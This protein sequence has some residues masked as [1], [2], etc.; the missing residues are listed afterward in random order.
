[1]RM[2]RKKSR[3]MPGKGKERMALETL[4]DTLR[5]SKDRLQ[6]SLRGTIHNPLSRWSTRLPKRQAEKFSDLRELLD[7]SADRYGDSVLYKWFAKDNTTIHEMTYRQFRSQVTYLGTALCARGLR[8]SRI[9]IIS[10]ERPEWMEAF[11][12]IICGGGTV[13]PM[14]RDLD[15]A[16]LGS[17]LSLAEAEAV[18]CSAHTLEKVREGMKSA[19][20]VR[21]VFCFDDVG[22][23]EEEN[24]SDLVLKGKLL[25]SDG[26][27]EYVRARLSTDKMCTLLFTSGTTGTSK[28]VMLSQNNL[29][30]CVYHSCNMVD[31]HEGEVL[32]SVLPMHHTYELVCGQL[33]AIC[34]GATVCFNNSLKY[35]MRNIKIFRPT[36]MIV[37]PV[38]VTS[39]YRKIREEIDKKKFRQALNVGI[40]VTSAVNH[41][42]LNLG[43]FLFYQVRKGL[44]GR[45]R[46][47]I[48]GGA[49]LNP[50]MVDK[51]SQFGIRICQG[52]G[53]TECSP[54]VCVVPYTAMRK[55]SVGLPAYGTEVRIVGTDDSGKETELP[56]HVIG[57]IQIRSPQ[58]MLGYYLDQKATKNAMTND[59]F[60]RS[61]DYGYIDNDGYLYITG[62]KKNIIILS[63]GKNVYPEELEEYLYE[64]DLV[65]DCVVLARP[66]EEGD[67]V[68][69]AVIYP[70][71]SRLEGKSDQEI[72]GEFRA[73]V[74]AVN[75]RL[76]T[77]KQIRNVELRKTE[78]EKTTTQKI[79]RYK[80]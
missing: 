8:S 34:L 20:T 72:I 24:V 23:G 26:Y 48:C 30:A 59:G 65:K 25:L 9:A 62:R 55:G 67:A 53:I 52:Y 76:P 7:S 38:F 33:G 35:F 1:M 54:L 66:Q 51:F 78:F 75:K 73:I 12:A 57:E 47:I 21:F 60:F 6:D 19:K 74:A 80:V 31:I 29:T 17:F 58:V 37:V 56:T 49:A 69:T 41:V 79:Q 15:A 40:R 32:M 39:V 70:D 61:G 3:Q 4:R 11:L 46:T 14:D 77:F 36:A 2:F 13:V 28:G 63:N 64:N 44:G 27:T 45:L 22:E 43:S 42:G 71:F 18:F 50:E 68:I 5:D 16:H 10:E